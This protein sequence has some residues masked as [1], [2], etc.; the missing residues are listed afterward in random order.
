MRRLLPTA[1]VCCALLRGSLAAADPTAARPSA[2]EEARAIYRRGVLAYERG[3]YDEA[4]AAFD[5]AY[6]LTPAPKLLFNL[7]QSYRRK[8]PATCARAQEY[9]ERYLRE[10]PTASNSV[11][12]EQRIAEMRTCHEQMMLAQA[13]PTPVEP[14]FASSAA[15][16]SERPPPR[17]RGPLWLGA[18]GLSLAIAGGVLNWRAHARF[19]E[20]HA[21]CPCPESA[22]DGWETATDVSYA[23]LAAGG[24]AMA[25]GLTWWLLEPRARGSARASLRI[26]PAGV[27][28]SGAF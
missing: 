7:A 28:A 18:A 24:A 22:F 21:S 25:A 6:A 1:L 8:G 5:R 27:F 12:T 14:A 15:P 26:K 19:D 13:P 3:D 9:Y 17:G 10:S 16:A 11:E 23:L 20:L 4:I 2:E